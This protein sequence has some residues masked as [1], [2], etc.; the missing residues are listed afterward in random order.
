MAIAARYQELIN[1]EDDPMDTFEPHLVDDVEGA[2]PTFGIDLILEICKNSMD[3][4][5]RDEQKLIERAAQL[6][7]NKP[8]YECLLGLL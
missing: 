4:L 5:P 1:V 6:T 8:L 3:K 2:P 7:S